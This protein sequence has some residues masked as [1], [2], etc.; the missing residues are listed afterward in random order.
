MYNLCRSLHAGLSLCKHQ[1]AQKNF[2]VQRS[3]D[4]LLR[5][6]TARADRWCD[7]I[8]SVLREQQLEACQERLTRCPSQGIFSDLGEE[9][10]K[11]LFFFSF[12]AQELRSH[13]PSREELR[14][15]VMALLEWEASFLSPREDELVKRMLMNGGQ[16]PLQDWDEISAAEALISRLWCTLQISDDETAILQLELPLV[17][18]ITNAMLTGRYTALR[19]RIFSF[20][21]TLHS[22]LYL[23]G[24]LHAAVPMEHFKT[25]L[26][27]PYPHLD[28]LI[29]RY[30]RSAFDYTQTSQGEILLLH[31]GLAEPD[32]L[33]SML[34]GTKPPETHLTREM[35]LGGMNGIL[36]EEIASSEAMRG[37]IS[38][39]VRPEYDEEE[40]LED[41][42]MMAKQGAQL[43]EMREVM[44]SMLCVLPT[45]RM[46]S[47]LSQLHLQTVRWMGMPSAVLN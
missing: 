44:E 32:R 26:Q 6:S 30:L 4:S 2:R 27:N 46:L 33:L 40:A 41:L 18:P 35:M 16:T 3:D 1:C 28:R 13:I 12:Y 9:E 22:L 5:I 14:K 11:T 42:R 20:D 17:A 43:A 15:E 8:M 36:P 39:A 24:F 7:K 23:S 25:A 31:P 37:A 47:A 34:S 10:T 38:G 45:P 21:A 29:A 19:Q